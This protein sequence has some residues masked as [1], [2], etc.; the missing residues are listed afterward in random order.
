MHA[1]AFYTSSVWKF[2][3]WKKSTWHTSNKCNFGFLGCSYGTLNKKKPVIRPLHLLRRDSGHFIFSDEIPA[4]SSVDIV[5]DTRVSGDE[6]GT[7]AENVEMILKEKENEVNDEETEEPVEIGKLK[8]LR[9]LR[10][11]G[12]SIPRSIEELKN[13]QVIRAGGNKSIEGSLPEE[14]GN[15]SGLVML[16]I[17]ETSLS[18]FLPST[19]GNLKKL[20][21]LSIYTTLLSGRIPTEL[22]DCT[23]LQNI[24]LYEN[25]LSGSIPSTLGNL[26]NLKNLLLWQNNLVGFIP[27]EPDFIAGT[28][29]ECESDLW[30]YT[31][32]A[33]ELQKSH[34]YLAGE[35]E[36]AGISPK[37]MKWPDYRLS[38][39]KKELD[40]HF[41]TNQKRKD[42]LSFWNGGSIRGKGR[43][44]RHSSDLTSNPTLRPPLFSLTQNGKIIDLQ[45]LHLLQAGV[46]E[47]EELLP[48][49]SFCKFEDPLLRFNNSQMEGS[50]KTVDEAES[51][52]KEPVDSVPIV[53]VEEDEENG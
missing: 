28:S 6:K 9:N 5:D 29:V 16:G 40:Y 22:G 53:D 3:A 18:G 48:R 11:L 32:S 50:H 39:S 12:G 33:W 46:P 7:V 30:F 2:Y 25:S 51:R 15:C 36:V 47:I 10:K 14:I 21:T 43:V 26:K 42:G 45:L 34:S 23:E 49:F 13:P 38:W 27:P 31:G 17:A 37:K 52:S 41:G 4:S 8:N 35:D 44:R 1:S 19:I 20:Q 24:Y